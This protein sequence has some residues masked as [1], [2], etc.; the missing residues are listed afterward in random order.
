MLGIQGSAQTTVTAKV[1]R[2]LLK[3]GYSVGVIGVN[4]V[5]A[6]TQLRMNCRINVEVYGDETNANAID[7]VKKGLKHFKIQNIDV[8][9][10]DTGRQQQKNQVP[11]GN[12]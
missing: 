7:I 6:L 12:A 10:I 5:F 11:G 4:G 2:W 8:I 1:A 9:I 3:H